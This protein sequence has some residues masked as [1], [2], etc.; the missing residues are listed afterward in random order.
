[1]GPRWGGGEQFWLQLGESAVGVH[2]RVLCWQPGPEQVWMAILVGVPGHLEK[3][4][5]LPWTP[6]RGQ[7]LC[8]LELKS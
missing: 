8:L 3:R 4:M 7:H 2:P 5:F 1:M 6:Q